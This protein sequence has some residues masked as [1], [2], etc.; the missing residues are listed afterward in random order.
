MGRGAE[1]KIK[2]GSR[3]G[4]S[5]LGNESSPA[6][7]PP[8]PRHTRPQMDAKRWVSLKNSG[9]SL[10]PEYITRCKQR[11]HQRGRISDALL[12]KPG[13]SIPIL[14][15]AWA[16]LF[17]RLCAGPGMHITLIQ[18]VQH[19]ELLRSATATMMPSLEALSCTTMRP[20]CHM[21]RSFL[22]DAW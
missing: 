13:T 4:G 6:P 11:P 20:R 9:R 3:S 17:V 16:H 2:R 18:T 8:P 1:K 21:T 22:H 7:K 12:S 19:P 5:E 15:Q 14:G 10:N